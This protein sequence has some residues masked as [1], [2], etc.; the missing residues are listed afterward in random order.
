MCSLHIE[1]QEAIQSSSPDMGV[2]LILE[3]SL[4]FVQ[5][6]NK[7]QQLEAEARNIY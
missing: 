4:I 3:S 5:M 1:G 2:F 6:S 7:V